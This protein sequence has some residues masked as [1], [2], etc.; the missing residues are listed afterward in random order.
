M[1]G[2]SRTQLH[3]FGQMSDAL[4]NSGLHQSANVIFESIQTEITAGSEKC[5]FFQIEVGIDLHGY[6]PGQ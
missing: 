2:N 1:P 4:F 3:C 6:L 5:L